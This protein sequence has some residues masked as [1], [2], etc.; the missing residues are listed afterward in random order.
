MKSNSSGFL[1]VLHF[2]FIAKELQFLKLQF[3]NITFECFIVV[4]VRDGEM[5]RQLRAFIPLLEDPAS[6][7]S[8]NIVTYNY[9]QFQFYRI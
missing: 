3:F 1:Y 5:T 2:G 7:C 6:V 8:T 9:L 4:V